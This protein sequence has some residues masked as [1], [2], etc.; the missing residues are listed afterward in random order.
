MSGDPELERAVADL[1]RDGI[2]DLYVAQG[3]SGCS[4]GGWDEWR[5]AGALDDPP[6]NGH[7][8]VLLGPDYQARLDAPFIRW[9]CATLAEAVGPEAVM[10]INGFGNGE[11]PFT[12][13]RPVGD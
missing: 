9:G 3:G 8:L 10:V 13:I 12:I 4:P 5:R 6:S 7:D 1:N 2:L 11:G